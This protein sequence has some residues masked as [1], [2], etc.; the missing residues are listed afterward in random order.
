MTSE[1]EQMPYYS[2]LA[3]IYLPGFWQETQNCLSDYF[4]KNDTYMQA[5]I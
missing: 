4:L 3:L 5:L 2:L 1:S